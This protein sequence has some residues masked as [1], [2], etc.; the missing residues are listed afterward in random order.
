MICWK[1]ITSSSVA[2]LLGLI[3]KNRV[4]SFILAASGSDST[5]VT[6][7]FFV[8]IFYYNPEKMLL[9]GSGDT[10]VICG[11]SKSGKTVLARA[12]LR[13]FGRNFQSIVIMTGSSFSKDWDP[14]GIRPVEL[15]KDRLDTFIELCKR[16]AMTGTPGKFLL[17]CDDMQGTL[18]STR[19]GPFAK[20]ATMG[21]HLGIST[22][23]LTQ[24]LKFVSSDIRGNVSHFFVMA[25]QVP[26]T[27]NGISDICGMPKEQFHNSYDRLSQYDFVHVTPVTKGVVFSRKLE[28]DVFEHRKLLSPTDAISARI[29]Q[30]TAMRIQDEERRRQQMSLQCPGGPVDVQASYTQDNRASS[31]PATFVLPSAVPATREPAFSAYPVPVSA[32][33][34]PAAYPT[35][36]QLPA[37]VSVEFPAADGERAVES[38]AGGSFF[39]GYRAAISPGDIAVPAPILSGTGGI[40]Q[41]SIL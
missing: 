29:A 19:G 22:L 9:D 11:C 1:A 38:P 15:S 6:D 2:T 27:I 7:H 12:L 39:R 34:V 32:Y 33:P 10:C 26:M 40:I 5:L 31:E 17:V 20:L 41:S 16:Q 4:D 21:R 36:I 30:E 14:L 8:D 13:S 23:F 24:H 18:K 3:V 28:R 25:N 35:P 37:P